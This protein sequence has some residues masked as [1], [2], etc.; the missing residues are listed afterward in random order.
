[1]A[2]PGRVGLRVVDWCA[3]KEYDGA[4]TY[5]RLFA[6]LKDDESPETVAALVDEQL[7]RIDVDY[8]I[9]NRTSVCSRYE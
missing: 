4:Q 9:S 1:M 8:R 3:L 6:E 2:G 5:L 7:K